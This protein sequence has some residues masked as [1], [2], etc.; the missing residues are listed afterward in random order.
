MTMT[1]R[2][3]KLALT[4]HIA[5]SVGWLGAVAGFLVL[6]IAGVTSRDAEGVRGAY[7][8]MNLIGLY[9][10]VPLSVAAL[11]TGL[12]QC[13]GTEWGL[14]RH[15][16]I[17]TKLVLTI[18][19]T[20]LLM[21]H[22][23]GAVE[24]A[25]ERASLVVPGTLPEVGGLGAELVV[26]AGLAVLVLLAV[27]TLSVFKPWG[28]TPNGIRKRHERLSGSPCAATATPPDLDNDALA[29]LPFG[30]K[31]F[32]VVTAIVIALF[33]MFHH[34]TGAGVGNHGH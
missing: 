10:I 2:V 5:C 7:L 4:T 8:S 22:Q 15:Y 11:T 30:F 19:A 27:T 26:Q 33:G 1:P 13:L 29:S 3:T 14:F 25:A 34:L 24:R 31:I 23:F 6:S 32:A 28:L 16:W 9:M 17:L 21:M 20:G 18:G 12:V